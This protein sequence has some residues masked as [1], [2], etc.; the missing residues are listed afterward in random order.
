MLLWC[1]FGEV[2]EEFVLDG[3]MGG[4][5]EGFEEE[6]EGDLVVE[7]GVDGVVEVGGEE[8]DVVEVFKFMKE[9]VDK[10]VFVFVLVLF[11]F[12]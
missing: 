4:S 9:N 8:D 12:D 11:V 3:F 6:V 2:F 7:G 10:F 5:E 1:L